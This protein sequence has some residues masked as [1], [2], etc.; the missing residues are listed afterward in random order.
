MDCFRAFIEF[1]FRFYWLI[2]SISGGSW[3]LVASA[4]I[5]RSSPASLL[6]SSGTGSVPVGNHPLR[7]RLQNLQGLWKSVWW[8]SLSVSS[9]LSLSRIFF[10]IFFSF[11]TLTLFLSLVSLSSPSLSLSVCLS[12]SLYQSLSFSICLSLFSLFC[13]W[14]S[15][16]PSIF[17]SRHRGH[18]E[19][20]GLP[21][22]VRRGV[23]NRARS[24]SESRRECTGCGRCC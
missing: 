5:P 1:D 9:S 11:F 16:T 18:E 4:D 22:G 13:R 24:H 6:L 8:G 12:L 21:H 10:S 19:R 17:R 2:S 3:Q 23:A 15:V 7:H 14:I 20:L